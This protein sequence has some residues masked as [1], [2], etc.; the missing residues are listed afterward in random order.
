MKKFGLIIFCIFVL[1]FMKSS[2]YT[3]N[4]TE[5]AV[6]LFLNKPVKVYLGSLDEKTQKLAHAQIEAYSKKTDSNITVKNTP[7][8]KWKIPFLEQVVFFPDRILEYDADPEDIVTKDKKHLYV[9]N[10]AR[11]KIMNP[12]RFLQT[13]HTQAEARSR[14]DDVVYSKLRSEIG[15]RDFIEIIRTTNRTFSQEE[16]ISDNEFEETITIGREKI[17]DRVTQQS[18]DELIDLGIFIID[19]RIKRADLPNENKNSVYARM[20][21]ERER[22]AVKYEEEGKREKTRIIAET[23]RDIRGMKATAYRQKQE[24]M[25]QGDAQAILIYAEGYTKEVNE[26]KIKVNG[27]NADPEFYEFYK[28]LEVF[29]EIGSK[30][31]KYYLSTEDNVFQILKKNMK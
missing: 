23:D 7:G 29:E 28:S 27:Y 2:L 4:E 24:L 30:K 19:V 1:A 26:Q 20:I 17:M 3:I 14:I 16:V 31:A 10:Y 9:D 5:Q 6:V 21:K 15:Q 25:G 11:W 8:L 12:L 22:I 13:V 18:Y